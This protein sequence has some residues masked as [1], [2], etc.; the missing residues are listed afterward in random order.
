MEWIF[1]PNA[2]TDG[3]KTNHGI[4]SETIDGV[5]TRISSLHAVIK[6]QSHNIHLPTRWRYTFPK[7]TD[8]TETTCASLSS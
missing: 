5:D 4:S 7:E 2:A 8:V 6:Q 1:Q 3:H